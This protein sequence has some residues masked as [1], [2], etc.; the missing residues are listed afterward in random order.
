MAKQ[1]CRLTGQS[2][3]HDSV[4]MHSLPVWRLVLAMF[5]SL[6]KP[7]ANVKLKHFGIHLVWLWLPFY[8]APGV[9]AVDTI[10]WNIWKPENLKVFDLKP[11]GYNNAFCLI[12][13]LIS[14]K[15][16]HNLPE[17]RM[18]SQIAPWYAQAGHWKGGARSQ[19]LR[20]QPVPKSLVHSERYFRKLMDT[21]WHNSWKLIVSG[22]SKKRER[23]REWLFER[24]EAL[25]ER[26]RPCK[27]ASVFMTGL[28]P[29]SS[30]TSWWWWW[31]GGGVNHLNCLR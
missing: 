13:P 20:I 4:L 19:L 27:S 2:Q 17:G 5:K 24:L 22:C 25:T 30:E 11:L 16:W 23:E 7:Q 15:Q 3:S 26:S 29:D 14:D 6:G 18:P 28:C 8:N 31:G 21:T 12:S 9:C 10:A 1:N